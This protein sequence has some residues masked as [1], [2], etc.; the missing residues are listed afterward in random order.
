[1]VLLSMASLSI[2]PAKFFSQRPMIAREFDFLPPLRIAS[3]SQM[4]RDNLSLQLE[5]VEPGI[6]LIHTCI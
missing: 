4:S 1:M 6:D 3:I 5:S 2:A